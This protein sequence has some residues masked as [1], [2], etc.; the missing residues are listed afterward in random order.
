MK[1]HENT[2]SASPADTRGQIDRRTDRHD[3]TSRRFSQLYAK[4]AKENHV[5]SAWKLRMDKLQVPRTTSHEE[6]PV[7]CIKNG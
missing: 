1:H 2:S 5:I 6:L 3:E 7:P 4:S